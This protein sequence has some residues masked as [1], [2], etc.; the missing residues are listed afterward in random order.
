MRNGTT[1][2]VRPFIEPSKSG[3]SFGVGVAGRHPV[4]GRPGV[5]LASGVQ[6]K[7]RCSVR[8]TSLRVAAVQIAARH[9]LLVERQQDAGLDGLLGEPGAFRLGAIAPHHPIR[10]AQLGDLVDPL[11]HVRI[12]VHRYSVRGG[13]AGRRSALPT[14]AGRRA[15]V[16]SPAGQ[17]PLRRRGD[18]PRPCLK[19]DGLRYAAAP[20]TPSASGWDGAMPRAGASCLSVP[21]YAR[22]DVATPRR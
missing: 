1:Y 19:K 18:R 8:A 5:V 10:A 21:P 14:G 15:K 11:L 20:Q 6:M 17:W 12:L 16:F 9:L 7:V 4:V 3:A 13:I 2:I 22:P